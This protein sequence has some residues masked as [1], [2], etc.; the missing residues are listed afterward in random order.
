MCNLQALGHNKQYT[1]TEEWILIHLKEKGLPWPDIVDQFNERV[2]LDRQR[3]KA[4][5]ETKWRQL[6]ARIT[7]G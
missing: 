1:E 4:G 2:D 6:K 5:L 7:V 3:T